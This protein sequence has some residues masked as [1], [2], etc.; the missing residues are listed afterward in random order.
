LIQ[1]IIIAGGLGVSSLAGL[2]AYLV[3]SFGG[4]RD[5]LLLSEKRARD[6]VSVAETYRGQRDAALVRE[7]TLRD[8]KARLNIRIAE[9][10]IDVNDAHEKA[11]ARLVE[12]VRNSDAANAAAAVDILLSTPILSAANKAGAD[13]DGVSRA[14]SVPPA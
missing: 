14:G 11:R 10:E 1:A 3:Y 6:Q 13:R 8:D 2:V 7:A 5:R 9:L 12:S 4:W